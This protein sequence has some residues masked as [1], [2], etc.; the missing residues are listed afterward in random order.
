MSENP[1]DERHRNDSE[2]TVRF[3]YVASLD[4]LRAIAVTLVFFFHAA[5]IF[6]FFKAHL[7]GGF[8]GVDIFFVLSGFLIT[9]VLLHEYDRTGDINFRNFYT[10][11]FLRLMPAYWL[12]LATLFLFANALFLEPVAAQLYA[13]DNFVYALFYLTNWQRAFCGSEI[14]GL[15]GHTWS[16]AIEEQFYLVWAGLLCLLLRRFG[17]KSIVGVTATLVVAAAVFRAAR[18][19][20]EQSVDYL[21]NAFDSRIDALLIGCLVSQLIAWRI[22][23]RQILTSRAFGYAALSGFLIAAAVLFNLSESYKTAFLYQGG[24]TVFAVAVGIVVAYLAATAKNKTKNFAQKILETKAFVRVGKLSYGVYL[25]HS[26]AISFV[27]P[28][29]GKPLVRL[30]AAFAITFFVASISYHWLEMPFLKLKKRF[31]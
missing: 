13:D 10:R 17:R 14:A 1:D 8:L 31:E 6:P 23:P 18:W 30:L 16:L 3:E 22:I 28:I 4:G 11:R 19:R 25:W 27:F 5:P 21:Y 15:L 12:H 9:S 24:F 29:F 20:G 7:Q 26:A 2:K